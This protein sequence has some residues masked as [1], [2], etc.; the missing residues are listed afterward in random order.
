M[1]ACTFRDLC[2]FTVYPGDGI[3]GEKTFLGHRIS[4]GPDRTCTAEALTLATATNRC[5]YRSD[6]MDYMFLHIMICFMIVAC[7]SL[8][9][10]MIKTSVVFFFDIY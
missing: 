3:T 7:V 4:G 9:Y 2:T 8:L 10:N 6:I 5:L 1:G